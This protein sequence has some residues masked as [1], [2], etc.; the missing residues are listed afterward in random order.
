MWKFALAACVATAF[1]GC[2]APHSD[3]TPRP[4]A[5]W[6]PPI[7]TAWQ[8]QL[9]GRIDTSV[10]ADVFVVDGFDVPQSVVG[11]L[12]ANG[13]RVICYLSVGTFEEW[14]TD[15][16]R[17]PLDV[18]GEPL[19]QWPGEYW[20]DIR[21]LDVLEPIMADRMD[22]CLE[23]GFDAVDPDNLDG[24]TQESGFDLT[25]EDQL[26]FNRMIARLAHARSLGVGLKNNIE[27]IPQL[28]SD[29]DFAINESCFARR[30]CDQLSPFIRAGKAVLHVE[31]GP[32]LDEF[33]AQTGALGFDSIRKPRN[34]TAP[35]ERC[36]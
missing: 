17:F 23:K 24:Y 25:A 32:E 1:V 7:G 2:A 4:E 18:V 28:M 30:E 31:Y 8:Y 29:F 33:C 3:P 35:I 13:K 34:L 19:E 5:P 6:A 36:P 26:E 22:T 10:D 12:K 27:Q 20:L 11:D 15:A 21:R 16:S 9:Q 14:R